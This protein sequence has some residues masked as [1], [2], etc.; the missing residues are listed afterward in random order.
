MFCPQCGLNQTDDLK[1]CKTCGANLQA[2]RQ[3][4]AGRDPA[5]D[6]NW[7]KTWVAEM[8]MSEGER[9]RRTQE[10]E[11]LQGITPEMKRFTEIKAG[12][13]T[14]SVGVALMI[15]LYFLMQGIIMGGKVP[16]ETASILSKIW[17]AGVIPFFVGMGLMI[18]G[19]FVSK[20]LIEATREQSR[21]GLAPQ[22]RETPAL[23]STDTSEF[24]PTNLSVTEGT[25]RH[26][27]PSERQK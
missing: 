20:R 1:F 7:S 3:V 6:F 4:V 5:D 2:V 15:F 24:I 23:P 25:T 26:L 8:F 14:S 17:I 13:I 16:F 9:K 19:T 21:S 27:S 11:R 10:L 22:D 12:V 18:N